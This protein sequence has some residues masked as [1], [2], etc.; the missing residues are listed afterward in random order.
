MSHIPAKGDVGEILAWTELGSL[1]V[2]VPTTSTQMMDEMSSR[3]S[4]GTLLS[5]PVRSYLHERFHLFQMVTTT[6]GVYLERL[7][8]A[9]TLTI[10]Q[11]MYHIACRMKKPL[12]L[13]LRDYARALGDQDTLGGLI[14]NWD[15][16]EF[17]YTEASN[18]EPGD[19]ARASNPAFG[20]G[21]WEDRFRFTQA[22][23]RRQYTFHGVEADWPTQEQL[24][25]EP[26]RSSC[27][28]MPDT[29][30]F[31]NRYV[32]P[33]LS[34]LASILESAAYAFELAW[35]DDAEYERAVNKGGYKGLEYTIRLAETK[36]M[37]PK[38]WGK[39]GIL[40]THAA[41]CDLALNPPIL[42]QHYKLRRG[43]H[44]AELQLINRIIAL[45]NN[46][47]A[48]RPARGF[49]D[50]PRYEIELTRKLGWCG[51]TEIISAGRWHGS[52]EGVS[53]WRDALYLK[54]GLMRQKFAGLFYDP[55]YLYPPPGSVLTDWSSLFD[56]SLIR[57][58][59]KTIWGRDP[60]IGR[61]MLHNALFNLWNRQMFLGEP[62]KLLAPK[63]TPRT[64]VREFCDQARETLS[65]R[66]DGYD[67]AGP[68]VYV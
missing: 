10:G 61:A 32:T 15:L 50:A 44:S 3:S 38:R 17:M 11:I 39:E 43:L 49:D 21:R 28:D 6:I 30:L 33:E 35:A 56:F 48:V 31:A 41:L 19:F 59:D 16:L 62:R 42:P 55:R 29:I 27:D 60:K 9:Q 36:E 12:R 5:A 65:D 26:T 66:L 64:L 54:A 23:I 67:I 58:T 25:H 22:L 4:L 18:A 68:T 7:A 57:F 53:A 24:L 20:L 63:G 34:A 8:C 45:W 51:P 46:A 47:T 14:Q 52:C 1:S 37:L 40:A 2:T 13:P